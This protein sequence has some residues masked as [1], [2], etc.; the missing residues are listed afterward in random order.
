MAVSHYLFLLP[1]GIP[2]P[3]LGDNRRASDCRCPFKR[4]HRTGGDPLKV[5]CQRRCL[6]SFTPAMKPALKGSTQ[7][8]LFP[9]RK[10]P[11][12]VWVN[13]GTDMI[14]SGDSYFDHIP[15]PDRLLMRR[16]AFVRESTHTF[17]TWKHGS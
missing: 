13:Y 12:Y 8:V 11:G 10:E 15:L 1:F 16:L 14:N 2:R 6:Q 5:I 3:D 9:R 4:N 7:G 17:S